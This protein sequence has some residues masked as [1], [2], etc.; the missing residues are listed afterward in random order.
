MSKDLKEVIREPLVYLGEEHCRRKEWQI[1]RPCGRSGPGGLEERVN[2][3]VEGGLVSGVI[4]QG[5][6]GCVG[7]WRPLED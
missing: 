5:G 2:T 3:S 4:S 1:Q 7:P 6:A